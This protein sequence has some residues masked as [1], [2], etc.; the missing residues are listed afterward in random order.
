MPDPIYPYW[1]G[2]SEWL[3]M[4]KEVQDDIFKRHALIGGAMKVY[5]T[6]EEAHTERER[7]LKENPGQY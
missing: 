6:P 2:V 3:A 1:L 4:P 5:A 7:H